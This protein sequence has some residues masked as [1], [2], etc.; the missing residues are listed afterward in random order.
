MCQKYLLSGKK[1]LSVSTSVQIY[2]ALSTAAAN[3]ILL[4]SNLA[5]LKGKP[6]VV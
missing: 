5:L 4:F 3:K 2:L 1:N 6:A